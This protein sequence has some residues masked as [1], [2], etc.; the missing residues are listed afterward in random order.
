MGLISVKCQRS[1]PM[2]IKIVLQSTILS[3]LCI[4]K[5]LYLKQTFAVFFTSNGYIYEFI[6]GRSP[7]QSELRLL[8]TL[9]DFETHWFCDRNEKTHQFC[10]RI[11]LCSSS[12]S[13][14]SNVMH[15][16]IFIVDSMRYFQ[17]RY[18]LRQNFRCIGFSDKI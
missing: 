2:K 15:L 18:I 5:R 10:D 8:I 1:Y 6:V 11:F 17:T 12:S 16:M 13:S 7:R 14:S 3:I 4:K 9:F